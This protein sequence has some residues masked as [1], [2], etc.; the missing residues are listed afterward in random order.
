MCDTFLVRFKILELQESRK[1]KLEISP[2]PLHLYRNRS[3]Y[4]TSFFLNFKQKV[5]IL[6]KLRFRKKS[7]QLKIS[8]TDFKTRFQTLI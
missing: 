8:Q 3:F 2:R 5:N 1:R 7:I 4:S 6:N